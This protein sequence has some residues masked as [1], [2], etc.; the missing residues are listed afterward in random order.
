MQKKQRLELVYQAIGTK[1]DFMDYYHLP[2]GTYVKTLHQFEGS[3]F[4]KGDIL[5]FAICPADMDKYLKANSFGPHGNHGYVWL[6]RPNNIEALRL[7]PHDI[8]FNKY[9]YGIYTM[10]F[11]ESELT[12]LN[13]NKDKKS[14]LDSI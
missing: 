8:Y 3:L 10:N 13:S 12:V 7:P 1:E 11:F 2:A 14:L 5:V 4:N 9:Q 6:V